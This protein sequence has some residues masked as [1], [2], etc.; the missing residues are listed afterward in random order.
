LLACLPGEPLLA[1]Q[2]DVD[3]D[4]HRGLTGWAGGAAAGPGVPLP[5]D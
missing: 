3:A 4:A 2:R 1:V 5:L